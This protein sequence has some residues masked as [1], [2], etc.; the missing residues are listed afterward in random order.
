MLEEISIKFPYFQKEVLMLIVV[1]T[2]LSLLASMVKII[3]IFGKTNSLFLLY[4]IPTVLIFLFGSVD[5]LFFVSDSE[6]LNQR[7][8]ST[9]LLLLAV[10][11]FCFIS[12]H[13]FQKQTKAFHKAPLPSI[14][15][16]LS[17]SLPNRK[18]LLEKL[19]GSFAQDHSQFAVLTLLI[20][21]FLSVQEVLGHEKTQVLIKKF[22]S[23]MKKIT[24]KD[25]D[26]FHCQT[27]GF[28]VV[29]PNVDVNYLSAFS[30]QVIASIEDPSV[31]EKIGLALKISIGI[32]LYPN[33]TKVVEDLVNCSEIAAYRA[34]KLQQS[35]YFYNKNQSSLFNNNAELLVQLQKAIKNEAFV[36]YF[37][38][39][40]QVKKSDTLCFEVLLRWPTKNGFVSPAEFIPLAE[41]SNNIQAITP[42]VLTQA[43]A[44][45]EKWNQDGR[46]IAL[47]INLSSIDIQD[48]KLL[49]FF[50]A[51][52]AKYQVN[53]SQLTFEITETAMV[54]NLH[55]SKSIVERFKNLGARISIDD[56]GTGFS[57]LCVLSEMPI[58]EIKIDKSFISHLLSSKT[59]EAIVR[60]TIN[61]A[62]S[63]NC[64]VV[65]EG[66]ECI[67]I[68]NFLISMGCDKLQGFYY[69]KPMP[70]EQTIEHIEKHSQPVGEPTS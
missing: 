21:N 65:A 57:S 30:K 23:K 22:R 35:I 11:F 46:N 60:S 67:E 14:K 25:I 49:N 62:H 36:L 37:Q 6:T 33:Q 70:L 18:A 32:A 63:L 29:V 8:K 56:Y 28:C 31:F 9:A 10:G 53:A 45:L 3:R 54:Q 48:D 61:L 43:M 58:D 7:S 39:L 24:D 52:L 51:L 4:L 40:I 42:W 64:E 15:K 5:F 19:K 66:V 50:N 17:S 2:I 26:I 16:S 41:Q 27:N 44:Q 1:I 47:Q 34:Q 55:A 68:A 59:H 20:N 38:R 12:L 69:H 13:F